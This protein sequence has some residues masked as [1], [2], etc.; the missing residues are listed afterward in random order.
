VDVQESY[1]PS[2]SFCLEERNKK[3]TDTNTQHSLS[4]LH[5]EEENSECLRHMMTLIVSELHCECSG[6]TLSASQSRKKEDFSLQDASFF[7]Y[8]VSDC[9][10]ELTQNTK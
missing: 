6:Q 10:I 3:E 8:C 2:I 4:S 1:C 7:F 5:R 9:P